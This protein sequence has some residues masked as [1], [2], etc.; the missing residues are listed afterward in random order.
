M[1]SLQ[2][3]WGTP[4]SPLALGS[5]SA[6]LGGSGGST[7]TSTSAVATADADAPGGNG[8]LLLSPLSSSSPSTVGAGA[9]VAPQEPHQSQYHH[10][11]PS[12]GTGIASLAELGF[13]ESS[14]DVA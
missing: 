2:Q 1:S 10:R 13:E 6:I 8:R 9:V 4:S 7:S 11:I 3:I 14:A 5:G 12:T